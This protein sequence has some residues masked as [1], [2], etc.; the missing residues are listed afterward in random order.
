MM[1]IKTNHVSIIIFLLDDYSVVCAKHSVQHCNKG[2]VSLVEYTT[3][4]TIMCNTTDDASVV[5]I[6]FAT[7][8]VFEVNF[9]DIKLFPW[10]QGHF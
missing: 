1:Q 2:T 5:N 6:S 3:S 10:T 4:S 8:E 9:G 7:L